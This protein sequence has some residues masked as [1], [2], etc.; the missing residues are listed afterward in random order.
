M[1]VDPISVFSLA[2]RHGWED[3]ATEAARCSLKLPLRSFEG[4]P[5]TALKYAAANT[6]YLLLQYHAQ[7]GKAASAVAEL[8]WTIM[9]PES[10]FVCNTCSFQT[11]KIFA[12]HRAVR[13]WFLMYF[14]EAAELLSSQ[15]AANVDDPKLMHNAVKKMAECGYCRKQG[16]EHLHSFI[17]NAF[18]PKL[19]AEIRKVC[20]LCPFSCHLLGHD[21]S[22]GEVNAR[23]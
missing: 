18:K 9:G 8:S 6:Y 13:E 2:C 3:V 5:P 1:D 23:I 22:I 7:C 21:I 4:T 20:A 19:E 17:R 11:I 12:G 14:R 16:F 15:P 10:Y